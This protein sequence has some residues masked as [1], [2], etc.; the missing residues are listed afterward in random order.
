MYQAY[1]PQSGGGNTV[2]RYDPETFRVVEILD[3]GTNNNPVAQV[4]EE[5][6]LDQQTHVANNSRTVRYF[7]LADEPDVYIVDDV[8]VG[9]PHP[10]IGGTFTAGN[11]IGHEF[12]HL[13]WNGASQET[14]D[15]LGTNR[16][17]FDANPRSSNS[18]VEVQVD[19][20]VNGF[21]GNLEDD[22]TQQARFDGFLDAAITEN[23]D[24]TAYENIE[25]P[26]GYLDGMPEY[27]TDAETEGQ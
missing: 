23:Y 25:I 9:G 12:D 20:L 7:G 16:D 6:P 15:L 26:E 4:G 18:D 11:L 2:V 22:A 8:F 27:E 19:M 24:A 21:A 14:R 10:A 3:R 1:P 5:I 17:S 13:I